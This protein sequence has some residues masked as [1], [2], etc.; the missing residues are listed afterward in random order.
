LPLL[1]LADWNEHLVYNEYPFICIYYF[2]EWKL[3]VNNK[4][5]ARDTEQNLVLAPSAYWGRVLQP[6]LEKLLQKKL[7]LNKSFRADD[8]MVAVS[9]TD[10]AE[11]DLIKRFDE[12]D[13]DWQ[14]IERQLQA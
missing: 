13:I 1:Q 4:G 11:R 10:R 14:V 7:P 8:I 5:I 3:I 12:L 6:K 2:I 9:V